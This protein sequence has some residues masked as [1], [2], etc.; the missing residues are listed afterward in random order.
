M[1]PNGRATLARLR[2]RALDRPTGMR[3]STL[4]NLIEQE[5]KDMY[6]NKTKRAFKRDG[7]IFGGGAPPETVEVDTFTIPGD[8]QLIA[9]LPNFELN[10][11]TFMR[12][13]QD[14]EWTH[15][16]CIALMPPRTGM[17]TLTRLTC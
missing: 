14:S 8:A 11:F 2:F 6:G 7:I 5:L 17:T 12:V 1:Q 3:A 4:H 9:K 15:S 16:Y 10:G 13:P